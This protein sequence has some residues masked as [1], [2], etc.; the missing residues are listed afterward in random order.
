M[1]LE[2]QADAPQYLCGFLSLAAFIATDPD[3]TTA[4]FSRYRRL[5]ARHLLYLHSH[6]AELQAELDLL[7]REDWHG[8]LE[9]KQLARNWKAFCDASPDTPRLRRKRKLL[10][11]IGRALKRYRE[12]R[13]H[14]RCANL[15]QDLTSCV[16]EALFYKS[17]LA[18]LP[19]PSKR[20]MEAFRYHF[21]N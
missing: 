17:H 8:G 2:K 9:H 20:T 12:L 1:D 7:D 4:I 15:G 5:G 10:R 16:G 14:E 13:N 3:Q 21:H 19:P 6:L 11:D 18:S